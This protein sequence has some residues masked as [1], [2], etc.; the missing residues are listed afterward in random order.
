MSAR[1]GAYENRTQVIETELIAVKKKL[2]GVESENANLKQ[3]IEYLKLN[4]TQDYDYDSLLDDYVS[5]EYKVEGVIDEIA[6]KSV[7]L[8]NSHIDTQYSKLKK[9]AKKIDNELTRLDVYTQ[10]ITSEVRATQASVQN[11]TEVI[12]LLSDKVTQ[13]NAD[14]LEKI[15]GIS[16]VF[17]AAYAK[18]PFRCSGQ[19]YRR[20]SRK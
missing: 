3:E 1:L 2:A 13:Q 16:G 11:S 20:Y 7:E 14:M 12:E 6:K 15:N 10:N 19:P 18:I 17:E 4:S 5:Q 9:K 8:L